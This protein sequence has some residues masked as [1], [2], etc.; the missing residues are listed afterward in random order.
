MH[1]WGRLAE[2]EERAARLCRRLEEIEEAA[3]AGRFA[4]VKEVDD[5]EFLVDPRLLWGP[6]RLV[7][8][9]GLRVAEIWLHPEGPE[10]SRP[11]SIGV[12]EERRL[13]VLVAEHLDDLTSAWF[14]LREDRR[15]GRPRRNLFVD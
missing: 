8:R 12:V 4:L 3:P 9:R 11:G 1:D 2:L 10:A 13:L 6:P 14:D 7:V 5:V 15:R